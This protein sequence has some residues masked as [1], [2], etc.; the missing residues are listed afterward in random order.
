MSS[1]VVPENKDS[2]PQ[3]LHL[4]LVIEFLLVS[5]LALFV[6]DFLMHFQSS[7]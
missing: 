5:T 6:G 4:D 1:K 2:E 3:L 7:C